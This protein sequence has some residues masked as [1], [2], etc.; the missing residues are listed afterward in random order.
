MM[1]FSKVADSNTF[2]S[3]VK[4]ID[5]KAMEVHEKTISETENHPELIKVEPP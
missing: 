2:T 1:Y 3:L 5:G 4:K